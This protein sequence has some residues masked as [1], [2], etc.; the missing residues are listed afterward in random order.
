[1][2]RAKDALRQ[3]LPEAL[4]NHTFDEAL[5][6]D[7]TTSRWLAQLLYNISTEGGS[8]LTTMK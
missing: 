4:R 5:K 8:T 3:C 2:N 1:M 6:D 7:P